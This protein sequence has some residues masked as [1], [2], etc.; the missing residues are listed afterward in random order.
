MDDFSSFPHQNSNPHPSTQST[1]QFLQHA[2]Y[3][4]PS[5]IP[6]S[7][8]S[9]PNLDLDASIPSEYDLISQ[10]PEDR[11]VLLE[12]LRE[13]RRVKEI[14]LRILEEKR[15]E[16]EANVVAAAATAT[17]VPGTTPAVR[18]WPPH[19]RPDVLSFERIG[20]SAL[21][22]SNVTPQ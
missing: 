15:R 12:L 22:A 9:L 14:E 11:A 10:S 20:L 17:G 13:R 2:S 18:Q 1:A 5:S 8:P 3:A 16:R 4:I 21:G 6:G 19:Q 7:G